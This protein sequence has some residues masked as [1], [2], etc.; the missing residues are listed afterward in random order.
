MEYRTY[1]LLRLGIS[2]DAQGVRPTRRLMDWLLAIDT[3]DR[4]IEREKLARV[5]GAE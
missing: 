5:M 1:R 4:A 3:T 2:L